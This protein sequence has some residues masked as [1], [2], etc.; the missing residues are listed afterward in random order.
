MPQPFNVG[1]L[2]TTDVEHVELGEHHGTHIRARVESRRLHL[3]FGQRVG[4]RFSLARTRPTALHLS[5]GGRDAI[6]PVPIPRDP[7]LHAAFHILALTTL[8]LILRPLA[9]LR[10][11]RK[12]LATHHGGPHGTK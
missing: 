9:P 3:G 4:F 12:L 5:R 10:G 7:W 1:A 8:S 2:L 11:P 6:I